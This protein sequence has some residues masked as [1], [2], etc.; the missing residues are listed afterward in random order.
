[1]SRDLSAAC[2]SG[3]GCLP[4]KRSSS[5]CWFARQA[6]GCIHRRP[7]GTT[8]VLHSMVERCKER[9]WSP[10]RGEPCL[11]LPLLCIPWGII[12]SLSSVS[13][14]VFASRDTG[15]SVHMKRSTI[16]ELT[17]RKAAYP[18]TLFYAAF[19]M[20]CFADNGN[21]TH[22]LCLEGRQFTFNLYPHGGE[23]RGEQLEAWMLQE[24]P[25][26]DHPFAACLHFGSFTTQGRSKNRETSKA[27]KY[28]AM[29]CE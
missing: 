29:Q 23:E 22:I 7:F 12:Y 18:C 6:P 2:S 16:V 28:A 17:E 21:R 11:L 9:H 19:L 27:A 13:V 24:A 8:A 4:W 26:R 25:K 3:L 5:S 1:M 10:L 14:S 15:H 20:K